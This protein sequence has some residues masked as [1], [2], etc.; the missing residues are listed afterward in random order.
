[1]TSPKTKLTFGN[2]K[3]IIFLVLALALIVGGSTFLY[4]KFSSNQNLDNSVAINQ[5]TDKTNT[6]TISIQKST[7]AK[8]LFLG[9]D[10]DLY[11]ADPIT[12]VVTRLTESPYQFQGKYGENLVFADENSNIYYRYDIDKK[13]YLPL[14]FPTLKDEGNIYETL[15]LDNA[16]ISGGDQV[17]ISV[18]TY[19]RSDDENEFYGDRLPKDKKDYLFSFSKNSFKEAVNIEQARKLLGDDLNSFSGYSLLGLD[20]RSQRAFFQLSGEGVGCSDIVVVSLVDNSIQRIDD[21]DF[22]DEASLNCFYVNPNLD[23]GF[24]TESRKDSIVAN[25]VSLSNIE[26]PLY[27]FDITNTVDKNDSIIDSAIISLEWTNDN[28]KVVAGFTD[29]VALLDFKNNKLEIIHRDSTLGSSYLYWDRNTIKSDG[30]DNIAFVDYYSAKYSECM[31]GGNKNC[32][33]SETR[34][35]RYKIIIQNLQDNSQKVFLDDVNYKQVIG[36]IK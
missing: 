29:Q 16:L 19:D 18:F 12:Q 27:T 9:K 33:S 32:P 35:N 30:K 14:N 2:L 25:L 31:P 3:I 21:N 13:E 26:R 36:W 24:Y 34:N 15:Y 10:D 22:S 5:P 11:L 23:L 7:T 6:P 8:L 4:Q 17:S 20:E 28:T 1:M